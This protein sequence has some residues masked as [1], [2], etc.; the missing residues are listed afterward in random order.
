MQKDT[1]VMKKKLE[2]W[3]LILAKYF[4]SSILSHVIIQSPLEITHRQ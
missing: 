1:A 2:E 3:L 4:L